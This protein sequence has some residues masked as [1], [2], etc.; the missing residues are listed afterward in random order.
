MKYASAIWWRVL[1]TQTMQR[2]IC[3]P[4]II[5]IFASLSIDVHAFAQK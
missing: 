1:T 4:M 5:D 2:V 3:L